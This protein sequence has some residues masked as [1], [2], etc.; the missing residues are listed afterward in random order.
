MRRSRLH[1][2]GQRATIVTHTH[3]AGIWH[4]C[5]NGPIVPGRSRVNLSWR[6]TIPPRPDTY[7]GR[8]VGLR[9]ASLELGLHRPAV[10]MPCTKLRM[11]RNARV[12][13]YLHRRRAP[14]ISP[15]STINL[16]RARHIAI[17]TAALPSPLTQHCLTYRQWL[18]WFCEAG[19]SPDE[20]GLEQT[21]YP[22]QPH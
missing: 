2:T 22:F 19:G 6:R 14:S 21:P 17:A 16:S 3:I 1:W 11:Q 4:D 9:Q 15:H 7:D 18:K 10:P 8:S 5:T 12:I 20:A 13:V